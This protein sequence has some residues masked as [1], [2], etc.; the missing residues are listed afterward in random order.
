MAQVRAL[1]PRNGEKPK[2]QLQMG[3]GKKDHLLGKLDLLVLRVLACGGG[4]AIAER[5]E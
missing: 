5:I 3:K 1:A 4:F 2:A